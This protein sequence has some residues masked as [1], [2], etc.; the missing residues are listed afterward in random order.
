MDSP[1]SLEKVMENDYYLVIAM[2]TDCYLVIAMLT[3]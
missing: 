2:V 3:D 1:M